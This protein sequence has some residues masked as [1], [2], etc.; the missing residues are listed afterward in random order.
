MLA[1]SEAELRALTG[2]PDPL[3]LEWRFDSRPVLQALDVPILWLLAEKD[4]EA[5]F[6]I[7]AGRI[8]EL[9]TVLLPIGHGIE[10]S[11]LWKNPLG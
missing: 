5:P 10:L 3:G 7:T 8:S 9:Q 4:R 11:C 6:T 2:K 1:A